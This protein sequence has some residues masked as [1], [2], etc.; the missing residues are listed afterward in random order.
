MRTAATSA[1]T[2][3]KTYVVPTQRQRALSGA[4]EAL[5]H[6][7]FIRF[8]STT[9]ITYAFGLFSRWTYC[10]TFRSTLNL[11]RLPLKTRSAIMEICEGLA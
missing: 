10:W 5:R 6:E 11:P 9:P 2:I 7:F 1:I 4:G 8:M 3:Q